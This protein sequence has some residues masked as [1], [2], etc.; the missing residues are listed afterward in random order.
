MR[1]PPP[2]G[3]LRRGVIVIGVAVLGVWSVP[4]GAG[5][6]PA[7]R[8]Y[9][10]SGVRTTGGA[11][12]VVGPELAPGLYHDTFAS[13][14]ASYE[15][16]T[17]KYY[18]V[19]LRKGE[20]PYLSVTEAPRGR[21]AASDSAL[22]VALSLAPVDRSVSGCETTTSGTGDTTGDGLDSATAVLAPGVVGGPGWNKC[23][24]DAFYALH[25]TRSGSAASGTALEMEIAYRSEPAFSA[26]TA[27]PESGTSAKNVRASG[28]G[29]LRTVI[30]GTGF[31]D[32]PTL[33]DGRYR[34]SFT[35]G[36]RRYYRV[37]LQWGQ[38][39]AWT[40]TVDQLPQIPDY[41]GTR[42]TVLL[43]NPVRQAVDQPDDAENAGSDLGASTG[44]LYGS[45]LVPTSWANR[46][47]DDA[48]VLP[49]AMDGDYYLIVS[50]AYPDSTGRTSEVPYELDVQA[51]GT[52]TTGPSFVVDGT[53][54][55]QT[56]VDHTPV[57]IASVVGAVVIVGVVVWLLVLRR[58]Q[59]PTQT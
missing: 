44:A 54:D 45:T 18:R 16:G 33:P 39:L 24:T 12:P 48:D 52:P 46:R 31:G 38:R 20:T 11:N 35:T 1:R 50:T 17:A 13:A 3:L 14:G 7:L 55:P 15:D 19:R 22:R 32:A 29:P 42:G 43:A 28:S 8:Y 2:P 5:A 58:R 10:A 49:Y 47:S 30:G 37:H 27:A 57:V 23:P 40:L 4:A 56:G 59:R 26:P 21:P 41:Q 34:D 51:V 36:E 9:T 25:V 53:A 6:A